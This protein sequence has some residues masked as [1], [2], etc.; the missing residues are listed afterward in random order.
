MP[1]VSS[2]KS[3][4]RPT[5]QICGNQFAGQ[6]GLS[7]HKRLH[8]PFAIRYE[9]LHCGKLM[10]QKANLDS[11]IE[12][13]HL[14]PHKCS[15]A[16]CCMAFLQPRSLERHVRKCKGPQHLDAARPSSSALSSKHFLPGINA[17]ML[18]EGLGVFPASPQSDLDAGSP[19]ELISVSDS[20]PKPYE[21]PASPAVS[22]H[23]PDRQGT[24]S[25]A[26]TLTEIEQWLQTY[27]ITSNLG[28][29]DPLSFDSFLHDFSFKSFET[30]DSSFS[31]DFDLSLPSS[32]SFPAEQPL[33]DFN[34]DQSVDITGS[35]PYF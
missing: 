35:F 22:E 32:S 2:E 27:S 19:K 11:H 29:T 6:T 9:C 24:N 10:S 8:D 7:R 23:Q 26:E 16:G 17:G 20:F 33:F 21:P 3:K 25:N 13:L 34:F 4:D 30:T 14:G 18:L 15:V 12:K 1:R 5:C 31:F 28:L